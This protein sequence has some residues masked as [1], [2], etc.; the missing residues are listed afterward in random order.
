M[1]LTQGWY[2][3]RWWEEEGEGE[4]GF[5]ELNCTSDQLLE[6]LYQQRALAINHYPFAP[7]S[8]QPSIIMLNLIALLL[9]HKQN[10]GVSTFSQFAYDA[11]WSVALALNS[12]VQELPHRCGNGTSFDDFRPLDSNREVHQCIATLLS[13][14]IS[15]VS[16][17][18]LSVSGKEGGRE[19][20]SSYSSLPSFHR[21]V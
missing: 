5:L 18:G 2:E 15:E 1:W 6:F 17:D 14:E 20:G 11:V 12:T 19:G 10:E 7:V 8:S 13:N 3:A 16:F 4:G 21:V 9:I